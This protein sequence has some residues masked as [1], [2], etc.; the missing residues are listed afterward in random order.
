LEQPPI[1]K[2]VGRAV[3]KERHILELSQQALAARAA[4]NPKHLSEIERGE[5]DLHVTTFHKCALGLGLS[6][7]ALAATVDEQLTMVEERAD[8]LG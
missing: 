6:Y 7:G 8:Q 1:V 3:R 5:R 2:A 4:V